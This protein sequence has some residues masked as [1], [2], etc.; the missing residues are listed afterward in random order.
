MS[1]SKT[2]VEYVTIMEACK[3]LVWLKSF[4]S[5]L[6]EDPGKPSLSSDSQSTI[7][8]AKNPVFHSRMKHIRT[9]YHFISREAR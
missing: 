9:K 1:L 7:H 2:E 8:L 3:E 6:G 5:E 4:I